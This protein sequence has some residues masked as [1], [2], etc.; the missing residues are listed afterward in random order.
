[1]KKP[2][3]NTSQLRKLVVRREAIALL[4]PPQ[5]GQVLA[6]DASGSDWEPCTLSRQLTCGSEVLN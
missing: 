5:T 2:K 1:M 4:T 6:G 3:N